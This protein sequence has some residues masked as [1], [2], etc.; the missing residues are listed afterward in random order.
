VRLAKKEP[1]GRDM[2]LQREK[3]KESATQAAGGDD[4]TSATGAQRG[5][6][7]RNGG[8][9]GLRVGTQAAHLDMCDR[10]AWGSCS[11]QF[12]GL[13][14]DSHAKPAIVLDSLNLFAFRL[15]HLR[16]PVCCHQFPLQIIKNGAKM[17]ENGAERLLE[18]IDRNF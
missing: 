12:S 7:A 15:C 2:V 17:K 13:A 4:R 6:L 5:F 11:P 14:R 1:S 9:H 16:I 8:S 18:G 10:G 3:R